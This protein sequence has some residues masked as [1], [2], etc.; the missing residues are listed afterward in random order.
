MGLGI[1]DIIQMI[2]NSKSD[3]N[4]LLR[5]YKNELLPCFIDK[6]WKAEKLAG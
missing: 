3:G 6:E 4:S 2:C 5:M 1:T